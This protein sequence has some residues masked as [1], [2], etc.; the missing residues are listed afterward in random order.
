MQSRSVI[1]L[2]Y[3]VT[4]GLWPRLIEAKKS[5]SEIIELMAGGADLQ[6]LTVA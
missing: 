3:S 5:A 6:S 4:V 2:L 1:I